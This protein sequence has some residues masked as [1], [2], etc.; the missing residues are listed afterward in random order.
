MA[1]TATINIT[2]DI[3]DSVPFSINASM[4]MYQAGT[5]LDLE[6]TTGLAQRTFSGNTTQVVLLDVS[7]FGAITAGAGGHKV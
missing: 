3:T 5:T 6:E 2:S 4:T 1:T 7:T